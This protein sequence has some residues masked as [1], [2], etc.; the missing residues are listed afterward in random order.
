MALLKTR[1]RPAESHRSGQ[2]DYFA[3]EN[4]GRTVIEV[5]DIAQ[6]FA[7]SR[8]LHRVLQPCR[9][10]K[11]RGEYHLIWRLRTVRSGGHPHHLDA[12][13][14]MRTHD[15]SRERQVLGDVVA[16]VEPDAMLVA[17]SQHGH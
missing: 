3:D 6:H 2:R 12:L 9:R 7:N 11:I 14:A 5:L 17:D 4:V 10:F 8:A 16:L 1:D 13:D 15:A